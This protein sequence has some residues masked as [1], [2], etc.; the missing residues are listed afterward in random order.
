MAASLGWDDDETQ[1]EMIR[2]RQLIGMNGVVVP[3]VEVEGGPAATRS[4]LR[5]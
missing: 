3:H 1:A 5:P 4:L 2:Y